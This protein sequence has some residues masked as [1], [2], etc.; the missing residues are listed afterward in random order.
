MQRFLLHLQEDVIGIA[1]VRGIE[2]RQCREAA[3]VH[4]RIGLVE[5]QEVRNRLPHFRAQERQVIV[6]EL[7]IF[8]RP[9]GRRAVTRYQDPRRNFESF[10]AITGCFRLESA[11]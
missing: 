9:K 11:L 10:A 4:P 1:A 8:A 6:R 3:P 5:R 7:Q 2:R